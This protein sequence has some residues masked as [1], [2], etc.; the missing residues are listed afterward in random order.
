MYRVVAGIDTYEDGPGYK[1]IRI[2][3]HTG[4]GLTDVSAALQT[5][6]GQLSSH[7]KLESDRLIFDVEIP[8]NTTATIYIPANKT[9]DVSESGSALAAAKEIQVAGTEKEYVVLKTGSGKYHFEV[10][11]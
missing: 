11:R 1:H 5:Y 4:G 3:P 2:M 9:D 6:Y 10:K 7:W 8:S